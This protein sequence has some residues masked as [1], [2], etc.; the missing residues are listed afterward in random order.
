MRVKMLIATV[1]TDYAFLISDNL[2]EYHAEL[3][4][5]S[6][7]NTLESMQ[8]VL[9]R[10]KYDVAL[11]DS[12]L[13]GSV[14]ISM[15]H[16]PLLLWSEHEDNAA[17]QSE[18]TRI[19]KYQ[20]VSSIAATVL[21]R[22]AQ[23]S[24]NR[25][26]QAAKNANITAVWSPAGGVGKTTVALAYAASRASEDKDVF[27][28]NLESFSSTPGY[29]RQSGKSISRI[30]EM[31]ES[32]TGDVKMLVQGICCFES[33]IT[34]LCNPDNYDDISIL[35]NENIK[36]LVAACAGLADELVIDLSC[37]CDDRSRQVFELSDKI[38]IVTAQEAS[39]KTKLDQF[40]SQNNVFES[41]KEKT[42]LVANKGAIVNTPPV[43]ALISL[44][45]VQSQEEKQV[46]KTLSGKSFG[47]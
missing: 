29:F 4:E 34:Y 5:V 39:A 14:D 44:P 47:A 9:I 12:A 36:E 41:I 28:L 23:V 11:I 40:I 35:S 7:C 31:L 38:F 21:E 33:G 3:I 8:E 22:Y 10:R 1:D 16:L 42:T 2:S 25:H 45:Y 6:V 15:I 27:Y 43:K 17:T 24:N 37:S 30:F 26:S 32:P 46:Y 18:H 19:K 20:R 13:I